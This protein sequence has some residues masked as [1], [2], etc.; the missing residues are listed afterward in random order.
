MSFQAQQD[1]FKLVEHHL[2][3]S[4]H[5]VLFKLQIVLYNGASLICEAAALSIT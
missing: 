5:N 4:F 2:L 1:L 3:S